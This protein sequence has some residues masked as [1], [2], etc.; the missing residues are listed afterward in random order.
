MFPPPSPQFPPFLFLVVG[1]VAGMAD[2]NL[3]LEI[4]RAHPVHPLTMAP[5]K[6]VRLETPGTSGQL[7]TFDI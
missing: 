1:V 4:V 6:I 7:A 3:F 5:A 2:G